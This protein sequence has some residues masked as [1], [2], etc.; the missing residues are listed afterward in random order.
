[1]LTLL[2]YFI[3]IGVVDRKKYSSFMFFLDLLTTLTLIYPTSAVILFYILCQAASLNLDQMNRDI[4]K[5]TFKKQTDAVTY[6]LNRLKEFYFRNCKFIVQ[7]QGCFGTILLLEISSSFFQIIVQIIVIVSGANI[8]E[9]WA[10]HSCSISLCFLYLTN[11]IV[12]IFV[13]D[14]LSG[15]VLLLCSYP[16]F[17][18][19]CL[20]VFDLSIAIFVITGTDSFVTLSSYSSVRGK[21]NYLN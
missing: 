21:S 17:R 14:D 10:F 18:H 1:M 7:I 4:K 8:S 19:N 6:N 3:T 2:Y 9:S 12:V 5:L 13:S 15:K 16:E 20:I 11:M